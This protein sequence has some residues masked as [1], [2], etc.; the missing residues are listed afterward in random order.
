MEPSSQPQPAMGVAV[1]GSQVYPASAYP[2]A[3]TEAAPAVASAGLQS[4]QTF[5]AYISQMSVQHQI[6]Y[7]QAQQFHQQ[8]QQQQQQQLQQFWIERMT[9]N[10]AMTDFKNHN[11][12]LADKEDH[13]GRR[14]CSHDLS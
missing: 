5:P 8:L 11:L 6:V 3:A 2:P 14:G 12:P 9:E 1:G 4:A 13:E 7:Q 10:E